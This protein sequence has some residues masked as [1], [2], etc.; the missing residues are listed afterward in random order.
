MWVTMIAVSSHVS[1]EEADVVPASGVSDTGP[2]DSYDRLMNI[3]AKP[4]LGI[5][6]G[7]TNQAYGDPLVVQK[8][9]STEEYSF[10]GFQIG[11][12]YM[13]HLGNRGGA[14]TLGGGIHLTTVSGSNK[15][16]E[17]R[18]SKGAFGSK[19]VIGRATYQARFLTD[20]WFVP[21]GGYEVLATKYSLLDI[22]D[23]NRSAVAQGPVF[24]LMFFLNGLDR[25]MAYQGYRDSGIKRSYLVSEVKYLTSSEPWADNGD[26]SLL[27]GIRVE[28]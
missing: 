17:T 1:A 16:D 9:F 22:E 13:M 12:D 5:Y 7:Y 18:R 11:G 21:Y 23:G 26:Y 19:G 8:T 25:E 27:F 20:Q 14:V 10:R 4:N 3:E 15:A 24:G 2:D 28:L 6:I